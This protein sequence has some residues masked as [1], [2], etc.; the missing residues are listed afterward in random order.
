MYK[1]RKLCFDYQ[2]DHVIII[3]QSRKQLF[4]AMWIYNF[5]P[6]YYVDLESCTL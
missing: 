6:R 4:G 1:T 3:R 2:H 5:S